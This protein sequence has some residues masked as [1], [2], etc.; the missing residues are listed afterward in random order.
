VA[1]ALLAA[2]LAFTFK[3]TVE[4]DGVSYFSYLH[5]IVVDHSLDLTPEYQAAFDAG[6][7]VNPEHLT[8]I[9]ATGLRADF[10]PVGPAVLSLPAYAVAL[11]LQPDARPLFGPPFTDAFALAS[12]LYGLLA[13][14]IA[15]RLAL[16][17][18]GS[19][20]AASTGAL[21]VALATPLVYYLLY[22]PSYSHTF[23]AF[24]VGLFLLVWWT[25][26]GRRGWA[27]WL[28]LG[29]LGGLMACV[30]FQDGPLAAIALLDLPRARWRPVLLLPG[31]VVGFAPQLI[32]DS[33]LFGGPLP[34]RPAGQDLQPLP[35]HYLDVLF[36]SYH[37]LLVWTPAAAIAVAGLALLRA[38]AF[39]AAFV[40]A[41]LVE[42][43][44]NGAA[45]DWWGGFAFGA[46]RFLDLTPF[47]AVGLAEVA[48]RLP[49]LAEAG[50]GALAAW[51]LVLI[52]N[53][54]YVQRSDHDA[55]YLGLLWGQVPA[56]ARVSN[57]FAQGAAAR[58]LALWPLL[59][60]P[61]HP[62][63]GVA[64]LAAEAACAGLALTAFANL[65]GRT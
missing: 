34:V 6:V 33:A 2:L 5:A 46:R 22:E 12:L 4:G 49:R 40:Y 36:S 25:T 38:R 43:A 63:A 42:L 9:T 51:N 57:L 44:L 11:A 52:A 62:L 26:R 39:Q 16:A 32:V 27:G 56:L 10:F 41:F 17:L 28:L 45:P 48:R 47:F 14:A 31:L 50:A 37:G 54:T 3:P 13:V 30:R 35:G 7:T 60:A 24:A 29:L 64:L 21:A 19:P 20:A 61:P 15:W 58:D 53:L 55:G 65:R 18:T 8:T 59:H 23:S 1:G